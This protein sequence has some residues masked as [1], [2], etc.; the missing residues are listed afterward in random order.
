MKRQRSFTTGSSTKPTKK[1][2]VV[3]RGDY[4][5]GRETLK[6]QKELKAFDLANT[7]LVGNTV[8]GPPNFQYLNAMING[9]ELYQRV[10]RKVYMKSLHIR[11]FLFPNGAVP[12]NEFGRIIVFYD[13]QPNKAAITIA[14]LLQDSNAAAATSVV[15]E[16]NLVNRQR[17]KILRDYQVYLPAGTGANDV[18][19]NT[20]PDQITSSLSIDM[21]IKLKG[22]E[23]IYDAT[24]GGT[25]AD[26]TSGAIG[27]TFVTVDGALWTFQY[28][29][30]LRYYD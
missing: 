11:G 25:V 19:T 15:S 5:K 4:Q 1:R 27:I 8:A 10:G 24:N 20:L 13:S 29:S 30:R 28:G 3:R 14:N 2:K 7:G 16:I 23:A 9:A 17:I 21:F 26:I 22:L 12:V 6:S 18:S